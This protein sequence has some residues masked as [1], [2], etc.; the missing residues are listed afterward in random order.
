MQRLAELCRICRT[1]RRRFG[2][3]ISGSHP[4]WYDAEKPSTYG[5][6][7][8]TPCLRLSEKVTPSGVGPTS[9]G[10]V[11]LDGWRVRPKKGQAE[12]CLE[13]EHASTTEMFAVVVRKEP[14]ANIAEAAVSSC[15]WVSI[16]STNGFSDCESEVA[17]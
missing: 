15:A 13:F 2:A 6:Q 1:D 9:D 17:T 3:D 4:A 14:Q 10:P 8:K 12:L 5:Y 16:S 11:L 7:P